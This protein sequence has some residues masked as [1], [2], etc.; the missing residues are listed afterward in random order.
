[1]VHD[2]GPPL[3]IPS[4]A[5]EVVQDDQSPY[6]TS[7]EKYFV[8]SYSRAGA[9]RACQPS[10]NHAPKSLNDI[11]FENLPPLRRAYTLAASL[12]PSRKHKK[13]PGLFPFVLVVVIAFLVGGGIGGGIGS[14]AGKHAGA[15]R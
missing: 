9:S 10:V 6:V 8:R 4:E 15:S 14:W 1:M 5:P 7:P 13:T 2:F 12:P 3:R 11:P